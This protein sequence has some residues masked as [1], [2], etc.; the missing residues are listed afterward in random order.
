MTGSDRSVCTPDGS[1]SMEPPVCWEA[2]HFIAA[3]VFVIG[4]DVSAFLLY[5][6]CVMV[7]KPAPLRP[8][9]LIPQDYLGNWNSDLVGGCS[10]DISYGMTFPLCPCRVA[11]TWQQAGL[12]PFQYGVLLPHFCCCCMPCIGTYFRS[13]LRHRFAIRSFCESW[14]CQRFKAYDS[15][16]EAPNTTSRILEMRTLKL[17]IP[18]AREIAVSR[19]LDG[20]VV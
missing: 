7:R 1:W 4:M 19:Q 17:S 13:I 6:R 15:L 16:I 3:A 9:S 8:D 12:I 20:P 11:A 5:Y 14:S 18:K 2:I 10:A